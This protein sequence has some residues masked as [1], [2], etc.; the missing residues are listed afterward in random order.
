MDAAGIVDAIGAGVSHVS[1]G[2]A[3]CGPGRATYAE[4]AVLTTAVPKPQDVDF[5]P[6]AA[7]ITIGEAALRGLALTG[8]PTGGTVLVHGAAGGVG[9]IAVQLAVLQGIQ[10]VGTAAAADLPFVRSLGA[11]TVAY[12]NGWPGRVQAITRAVDGVLDTSGVG[13]LLDS[14]AL[15]NGPT[16]VVTL[17]DPRATDLG[18]HFTHAGSQERRYDSYPTLIDLSAGGRLT[19]RIAGMYE[20]QQAGALHRRLDKGRTGGKLVLTI[21]PLPR[22]ATASGSAGTAG[23]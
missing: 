18:V 1:V 7:V 20:L 13:V 23:V 11:Q 6:A 3:V 19:L 21:G 10:V 15:A 17:A 4:Y 8:V 9:S 2:D 14:V 12:G 5:M 16:G 22:T